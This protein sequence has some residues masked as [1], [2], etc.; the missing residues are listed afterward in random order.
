MKTTY[1]NAK[2]PERMAWILGTVA[3]VGF[4]AYIA[5]VGAKHPGWQILR[6][7]LYLAALFAINWLIL[8][9]VKC[10]VDDE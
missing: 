1:A 9:T 8:G 7:V 10:T 6:M 4:V 2:H 5:L 3:A